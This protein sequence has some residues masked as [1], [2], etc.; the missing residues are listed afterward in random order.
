MV[1]GG[2]HAGVSAVEELRRRGYDGE[3]VLVVDEPELYAK[4]EEVEPF[5]EAHR[6]ASPYTPVFM[7]N[8]KIGIPGRF[9][10]LKTDILMLDDYLTNREGRKVLEMIDATQMMWEAGREER[11]PVFYF[12][13]GEN[14]HNHYREPTHAEQIAQ[15][16]G[17]L[18]DGGMALR[19][20]FLIDRAGVLRREWRGVKADGHAREVLD[21]AR[22][23]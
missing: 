6:A 5:L 15:S 9:A 10:N 13:A 16:Y 8:T 19:G 3:V 21:F 14:L 18:L 7:N 1:V 23:L 20:T 12:L 2:S 11:K 4:S 17:V 22:T